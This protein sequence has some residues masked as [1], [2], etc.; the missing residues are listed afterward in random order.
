MP[1]TGRASTGEHPT[2]AAC[3][4]AAEPQLQTPL[5][6]AV[7]HPKDAAFTI[8]GETGAALLGTGSLMVLGGRSLVPGFT[9]QSSPNP[10]WGVGESWWVGS[11]G[12]LRGTPCSSPIALCITP[13]M[14]AHPGSSSGEHTEHPGSVPEDRTLSFPSPWITVANHEGLGTRN[15]SRC[16][17]RAAVG[18]FMWGQCSALCLHKEQCCV[19]AASSRRGS[20]FPSPHCLSSRFSVLASL[21][22]FCCG[23]L[24][25][26]EPQDHSSAGGMCCSAQLLGADRV[27]GGVGFVLVWVFLTKEKYNSL[28]PCESAEFLP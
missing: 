14:F 21:S 12:A 20:C 23:F 6:L 17:C 8:P 16:S 15:P 2:G 5:D 11:A 13:S 10:T 7:E 3:P 25:S 19:C 28:F 26:W 9:L 27:G 18:G 4:G 22:P 1:G 24:L